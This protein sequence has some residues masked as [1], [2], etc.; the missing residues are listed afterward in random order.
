MYIMPLFASFSF[1]F[2]ILFTHLPSPIFLK[3]TSKGF[4]KHNGKEQNRN[5]INQ[6]TTK[7]KEEKIERNKGWFMLILHSLT[8]AYNE[9]IKKKIK[10]F[11]H[12]TI[13]ES[14]KIINEIK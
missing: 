6:Q 10:Q 2:C 9:Y 4:N 1:I 14:D 3:I 12:K 11:K 8:F 13:L 5:E 7:N